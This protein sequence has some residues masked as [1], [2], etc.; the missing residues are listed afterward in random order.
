MLDGKLPVVFKAD[1]AE[2][3]RRAIRF[4]DEFKIKP[5]IYGGAEAWR[6]AGLLKARDIPVLIDLALKV[7]AAPGGLFGGGGPIEEEAPNSPKRFAAE[8]N[9]GSLEKAGVRFAF[10]SAALDRP[11]QILPQI[12]ASRSARGLSTGAALEALTSAPA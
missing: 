3:I 10:A 1:T 7:P 12:S 4:S 2:Q 6:V 5:V 9:P 8:S 11:E